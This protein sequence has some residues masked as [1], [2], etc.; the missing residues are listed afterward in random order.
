AAARGERVNI[1]RCRRRGTPTHAVG[2]TDR[3][4]AVTAR[5]KSRASEG[6]GAQQSRCSGSSCRPAHAIEGVQ[7]PPIVTD[8]DELAETKGGGAKDFNRE[9]R[10]RRPIDAV[11][12]GRNVSVGR[13]RILANGDEHALRKREA[14][15][16][17]ASDG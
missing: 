6:N 5:N 13:A 3:D 2:R 14:I 11:S 8:D 17:F 7:D 16:G 9:L 4:A 15:D 1:K 12:R 10:L